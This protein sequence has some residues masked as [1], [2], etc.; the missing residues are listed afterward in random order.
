MADSLFDP[1]D[2]RELLGCA[3]ELGHLDHRPSRQRQ[4]VLAGKTAAALAARGEPVKVL[5]LDALRKLLAR[6]D[7]L[8]VGREVV[9]RALVYFAAT[10]ADAGIPV[11]IDATAH[12][13]A[14][15]D[16]ARAVIHAVRRSPAHL[17]AR[18]VPRRERCR[19]PGHAPPG[20]W[21]GPGGPAATVPGVNVPYEAALNPELD[22][23]AEAPDVA[24]ASIVRVARELA[25]SDA[26]GPTAPVRPGWALWITGMP[27]SGKTTLATAVAEALA[28]RGLSARLLTLDQLRDFVLQA[29]PHFTADE[30]VHRALVCAAKLLTEAGIAVIIDATAPR[31]RW[32]ELARELIARYAEVQLVCPPE[33]CGQGRPLDAHFLDLQGPGP[34]RPAHPTSSWTQKLR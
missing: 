12:R 14:W 33:V 30:I 20:I 31:R 11:I 29:G 19:A 9:Y 2:V 10:L 4:S 28:T 3:M 22:T 7:L 15:R 27:G 6:A 5:E 25:T 24:L 32:R 21:R 1:T 34:S 18:G 17:P 26:R 23:A 16:L 8:G 13:R